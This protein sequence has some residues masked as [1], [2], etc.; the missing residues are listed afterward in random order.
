MCTRPLFWCCLIG[1]GILLFA[2]RGAG[3]EASVK[4]II[5][6]PEGPPGA[7]GSEEADIPTLTPYPA[8][9][10]KATGAAVILCPGGGYHHLAESHGRPVAR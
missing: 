6:W 2:S 7:L 5:L 10:D 3:A 4:P 8:P 9:P 1:A